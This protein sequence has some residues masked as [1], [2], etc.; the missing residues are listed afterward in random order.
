[1][2]IN[3][4]LKPFSTTTFKVR[5]FA[6]LFR[7]IN[8]LFLDIFKIKKKINIKHEKINFNFWYVPGLKKKVGEGGFIFIEKKLRI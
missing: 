6:T 5:P 1:M 8:L 7:S 4:Y 2:S 3:Y